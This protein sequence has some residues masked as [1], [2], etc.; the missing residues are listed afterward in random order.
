MDESDIFDN[1]DEDNPGTRP[2]T[3]VT[4]FDPSTLWALKS[5]RE[6]LKKDL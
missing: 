5:L 2:T 1:D 4:N 3:A 6:K